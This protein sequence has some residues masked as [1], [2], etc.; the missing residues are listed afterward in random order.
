MNQLKIKRFKVI[1]MAF[2]S[3]ILR[4]GSFSSQHGLVFNVIV[5]F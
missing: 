1:I 3:L 4:K 2:C 5:M